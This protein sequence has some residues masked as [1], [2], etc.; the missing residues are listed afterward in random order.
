MNKSLF[1][2]NITIPLRRVP[3]V[4]PDELEE[5]TMRT[6]MSPPVGDVQEPEP[7]RLRRSTRVILRPY[8]FTYIAHG[9]APD[10]TPLSKHWLC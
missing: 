7:L 9:V 8:Y 2:T 3:Y 5:S 6:M 1:Q 4:E 10:E